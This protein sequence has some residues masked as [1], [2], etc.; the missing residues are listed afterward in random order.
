MIKGSLQ[1]ELGYF[2]K[3]LHAEEVSVRTVTKG[4]FY[5]SQ[6]ETPLSGVH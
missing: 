1:D 3:A 4:V 6:E 2:F 5:Q